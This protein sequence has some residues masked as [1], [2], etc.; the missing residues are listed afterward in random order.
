[1]SRE[2]F[3]R[4]TKRIIEHTRKNGGNISEDKARK[5]AGEVANRHDQKN[6]K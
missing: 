5:I 3:E 2:A 4:M 6:G 1:M